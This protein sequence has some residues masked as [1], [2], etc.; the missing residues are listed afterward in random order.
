M[1]K[2]MT[3]FVAGGALLLALG[4]CVVEEDEGAAERVGEAMDEAGDDIKDAVD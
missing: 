2:N 4:G 3:R 1:F